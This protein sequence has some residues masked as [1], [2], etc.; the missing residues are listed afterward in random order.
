MA[1]LLRVVSAIRFEPVLLEL[2]TIVT[3]TQ[4]PGDIVYVKAFGKHIIVINSIEAI[5]DLLDKRSSKY[6]SRPRLPMV[7]EL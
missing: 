6:S 3:D 1:D 2:G 7:N 5:S 4:H